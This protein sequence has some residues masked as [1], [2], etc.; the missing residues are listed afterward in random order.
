MVGTDQSREMGTGGSRRAPPSP[1]SR[2][3]ADPL[4]LAG[5]KRKGLSAQWAQ[6]DSLTCL[7]LSVTIPTW[8]SPDLVTVVPTWA[9]PRPGDCGPP[10]DFTRTW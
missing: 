7:Y 1:E 9:S 8:A 5:H 3:S 10:L 2:G 6:P 4:R